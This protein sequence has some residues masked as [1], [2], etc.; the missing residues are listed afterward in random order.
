MPLLN[1]LKQILLVM[2]SSLLFLSC[3]EV[4]LSSYSKELIWDEISVK[5]GVHSLRGENL[6]GTFLVYEDKAKQT[7]IKKLNLNAGLLEGTQ[8]QYSPKGVLLTLQDY[9]DGALTGVQRSWH[10]NGKKHTLSSYASGLKHGEHWTWT[11]RGKLYSYKKYKD[12][13]LVTHKVWRTDGSM[14]SNFII[15]DNQLIGKGG[16]KACREVRSKQG[17]K[18][19][20]VK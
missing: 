16:T 18:Y 11:K 5:D 15:R 7:L 8:Y 17:G 13:I 12:D 4:L 2:V 6:S 1:S 9:V 20:E 14:E 19:V 3:K 10:M